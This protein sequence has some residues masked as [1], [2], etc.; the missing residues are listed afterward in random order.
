[1]PRIR[2]TAWK[3]S[4]LAAIFIV[5]V[6]NHALFAHLVERLPM[7]SMAGVAY[8]ALI[9]S[10]MVAVLFA[11]FML[12]GVG[13]L[14]KPLIV[15]L[16]V[17]S[18]LLGFFT[19]DMGVVFD[20]EMIRNSLETIRDANGQEA[21]ELLSW[22]LA[23]YL[24]LYAIAPAVCVLSV[25][26]VRR[27]LLSELRSRALC[28][29]LGAAVIGTL[30]LPNYKYVTYFSVENRDLRLEVTPIFAVMSLLDF[31]ESQ[32][33]DEPPEFHV[34]GEDAKQE[35]TNSRRIVG[36]LVVGETAR[37]DHFSLDGYARDTNPLLE[38]EPG[39]MFFDAAS[40]GTSTA[41]SVPCMFS[42]RKQGDFSPDVAKYE[43]NVLDI[44]EHAGVEAVW[45][46]NN[47]SCKNVCNRIASENLHRQP[48]PSSPYYGEDA[49]YD[50]ILIDELAS[51]LESSD[52]DLLVVLH[53]LGSHGP[54]Y[55]RRYPQRFGVFSPY[56]HRKSPNECADAEVANAYD[57]TILYTDYILSQV[58][59]VLKKHTEFDSF[60]LYASDHGESLGENGVYLHGLP[61]SLA[62][63][64]QTDVPFIVWLSPSFA[65][66][67]GIDTDAPA[68]KHAGT[69]S[70]DNISH[71]LLGLYEVPTRV[72]QA[73]LDMFGT[74]TALFTS[75]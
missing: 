3:L 19:N 74:R 26:R 56:C 11:L 7:N 42:M 22:S 5:A 65:V 43:S 31:V 41:F 48:D 36:V 53:T 70:H 71:T 24:L 40:C 38:Q 37:A 10:L 17:L 73:D 67:S 52:S 25:Q 28:L 66:N 47:S 60:M 14:L 55:S 72:Y 49:Y 16:L 64:A 75:Q 15:A 29:A 50:E 21:I 9:A 27:P 59:G 35:K 61:Y 62:P 32:D 18:A 69:L 23:G 12:L 44:L 57:N 30:A 20:Q 6:N 68:A 8:L 63:R 1:L 39:L 51:R 33:R 45:I 4:L 58:I 13:P 46:D 2:L 34:V 54:A